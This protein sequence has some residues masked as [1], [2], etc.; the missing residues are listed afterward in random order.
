MSRKLVFAAALIFAFGAVATASARPPHKANRYTEV[1]RPGADT[2]HHQRYVPKTYQ[3]QRAYRVRT[4]KMPPQLKKW[5]QK[6]ELWDATP[7]TNL[8]SRIYTQQR[9]WNQKRNAKAE[10]RLNRRM[11]QRANCAHGDCGTVNRHTVKHRNRSG[12]TSRKPAKRQKAF[13]DPRTKARFKKLE[14]MLLPMAGEC[15]D[16]AECL[17]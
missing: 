2:T 16:A 17:I 11:Q 1:A 3:A 4:T 15:R 10:E 9:Q 13:V 5:R 14:K 6:G 8:P 7:H 12:N